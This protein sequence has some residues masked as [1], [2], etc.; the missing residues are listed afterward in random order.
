MLGLISREIPRS[1][2]LK[3]GSEV[4][5]V[6]LHQFFYFCET[7]IV[8]MFLL[9]LYHFFYI[10]EYLT[11]MCLLCAYVGASQPIDYARNKCRPWLGVTHIAV[12]GPTTATELPAIEAQRVLR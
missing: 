9:F 5:W 11:Y 4:R 7:Y 2:Y 1:M 6:S 12:G 3:A 10:P 8:F